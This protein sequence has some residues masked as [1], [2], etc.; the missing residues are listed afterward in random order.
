ME[1]RGVPFVFYDTAGIRKS[2]DLVESIGI[3]KSFE[4]I[5]KADLVLFLVDDESNDFEYDKE[6]KEALK[7]K[8][9]I[10]VQTKSDLVKNR[11]DDVDI[12]IGNDS[13]IEELY[14]LI[15]TDLDLNDLSQPG[16]F[17]LQDLTNLE[18]VKKALIKCKEDFSNEASYDLLTIN[19]NEVYQRVKTLLGEDYDPNEIYDVVFKNF[20]VGK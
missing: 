5:E 14:D 19:L 9:V 15:M 12:S 6:L 3:K 10:K 16:L 13:N 7:N 17:S 8:K 11:L 1:I 18:S 2:D 20:C 4:M